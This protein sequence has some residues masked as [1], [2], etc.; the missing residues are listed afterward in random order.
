MIDYVMGPSDKCDPPPGGV[1]LQ[2]PQGGY[3]IK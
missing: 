1:I 2:P 3:P